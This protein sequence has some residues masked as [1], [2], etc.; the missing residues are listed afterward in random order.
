MYARYTA[1]TLPGGR[2]Q[3]FC[4]Q[5]GTVLNSEGVGLRME[6][7]STPQ[8]IKMNSQLPGWMVDHFL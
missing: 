7:G 1:I 6:E 5:L 3:P 4:A 2:P 8:A